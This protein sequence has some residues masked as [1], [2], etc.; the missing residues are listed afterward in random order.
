M[1]ELLPLYHFLSKFIDIS[2]EEFDKHLKPFV[3]IRKFSKK[4][5]ITKVGDMEDYL[6]FILKG[7]ARKYYK[8]DKEEVN[9]QISIEGQ[10][11]HD[12]DSFYSRKPSEYCIEAIEPTTIASIS[13][14][15]LDHIYLINS[16]FERMGRLV[17]T[18]CMILN[19][20]WQMQQVKLTARD[21]FKNFV[22]NNSELLQRVPQKY[23]ASYL[24]IQPETF[25]RF[26][27]LLRERRSIR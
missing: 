18:F 7:L 26:K 14:D 6:N 2:H 27:H 5:T 4:E 1:E 24:N 3:V 17:V 11:I 25:S 19:D 16:K 8:R 21:R 9:T 10:I 22:H 12:Q 20:R 23:L 13:F 15:N